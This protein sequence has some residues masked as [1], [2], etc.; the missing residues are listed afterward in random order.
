MKRTCFLGV[1]AFALMLFVG[2]GKEED[3]TLK[4]C[5]NDTNRWYMDTLV[6]GWQ[7]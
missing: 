5:I 4:V 7:K 1:A 3:E 2:C 6:E